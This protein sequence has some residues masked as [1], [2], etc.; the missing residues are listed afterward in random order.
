MC[1]S[2]VP[3]QN[4]QIF[5]YNLIAY[6]RASIDSVSIIILYKKYIDC[7]ARIQYQDVVLTV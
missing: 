7:F 3:Q 1:A 2:F 4:K 5:L 6:I